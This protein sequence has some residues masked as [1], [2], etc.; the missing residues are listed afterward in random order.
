M[1]VATPPWNFTGHFHKSYLFVASCG[2]GQVCPCMGMQL[3]MV[4]MGNWSSHFTLKVNV[5][6]GQQCAADGAADI[7]NWL[8]QWNFPYSAVHILTGPR[9]MER[10]KTVL[11]MAHQ[12]KTSKLEWKSQVMSLFT[13]HYTTCF[14]VLFLAIE[15]QKCIQYNI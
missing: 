5:L 2:V 11:A 10:R 1:L 9:R 13:Q 14:L 6:V 8:P 3:Q 7:P 12:A 4:K 15:D